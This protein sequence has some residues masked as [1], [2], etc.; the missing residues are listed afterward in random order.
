MKPGDIV[1][2]SVDGVKSTLVGTLINVFDEE[3]AVC[4][5]IELDSDSYVV[6][7]KIPTLIRSADA[8]EG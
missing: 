2:L 8:P 5:D 1:S 4:Y 7:R 3:D 6:T